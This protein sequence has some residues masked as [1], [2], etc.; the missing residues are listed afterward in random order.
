MPISCSAS[1]YSATC[2][3]Q[4]STGD[5]SSSTGQRMINTSGQIMV[6]ANGHQT[7]IYSRFTYFIRLYQPYKNIHV[8]FST[9]NIRESPQM[10]KR[11][12]GRKR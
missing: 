7:K 1:R 10:N 11:V 2:T 8:T 4:Q 6:E 3:L 9:Q 5:V 12:L